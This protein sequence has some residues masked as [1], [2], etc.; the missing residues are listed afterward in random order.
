MLVSPAVVKRLVSEK[1][2]RDW[3]LFDHIFVRHGYLPV[4]IECSKSSFLSILQCRPSRAAW[5]RF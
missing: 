4:N 5:I 1:L 3:L 2:E